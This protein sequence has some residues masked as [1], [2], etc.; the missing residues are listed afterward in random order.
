MNETEQLKQ[1]I[2]ELLETKFGKE[3]KAAIDTAMNVYMKNILILSKIKFV[4]AILFLM[5]LI[6]FGRKF[7]KLKFGLTLFVI[8][9]TLFTSCTKNNTQQPAEQIQK[10]DFTSVSGNNKNEEEF[11]FSENTELF[12]YDQDSS[13]YS[14]EEF[15]GDLNGDGKNDRVTIIKNPLFASYDDPEMIRRG[16]L[17]AFNNNGN[18]EQALINQSCFSSENEHGGTYFAPELSIKIERGNLYISYDHG[19]YGNHTYTFRYQ[20]ADFELIGYDKMEFHSSEEQ[21][22]IFTNT[23]SINF[24]TKRKQIKTE[25]APEKVEETWENIVISKLVKL[26][27]ITDFDEFNPSLFFS[28]YFDANDKL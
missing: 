26:S 12:N 11:E 27:D 28:R 13:F 25:T 17:I 16:I 5:P 24:N 4:T 14:M 21:D 2:P 10:T 23:T 8:C 9:I 6:I 3:N 19:K 7:I 1:E 18:Y 22:W 15:F 20:N